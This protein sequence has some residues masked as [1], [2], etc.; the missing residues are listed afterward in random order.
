MSALG[1]SNDRRLFFGTESES[2]QIFSISQNSN[3][4]SIYFSAPKF[5]E[6]IWIVP[7]VIG[8]QGPVLLTYQA[9]GQGKLSLHGSGV[10]HVKPYD[11]S[12]PNEF[13]IRGNVL[14]SLEG[15][16]LS[17]RHLVTIFL[18]EPKHKPNS[19]PGARR[20]DGVITTKHWHPYVLVLWAVPAAKP[21]TVS[22]SHAFH[23]DDL[24]EVPPNA[25]WGAFTMALHSIVW[26][27]YRTKY[28]ERWPRNTHAC[29]S[30]GHTV[31]LIF[32]T[33]PGQFRL[34]YRRPN[35]TLTDDRLSIA[36]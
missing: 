14:R 26:F 5:E 33:G 25:G 28:M 16:T 20:S 32:G 15:N 21:M 12:R 11:S 3:D 1:A 30:D 10:T 4:G 6:I 34:E 9:S 19:P 36:L 35:Y 29:Y 18:S 8:D 7:A 22:V 24:E 17:V 31:P 2:F 23:E 13:S 27:A